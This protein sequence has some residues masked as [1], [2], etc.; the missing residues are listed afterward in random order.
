MFKP[1]FHSAGRV[2]RRIA[3]DAIAPNSHRSRQRVNAESVRRLAD[4]IRRHGQLVP[5]LVRATGEGYALISGQR[6]LKA[7]KLLGRTHV[8][9]I[10]LAA[11]E[12]DGA[13]LALAENMQRTPPHWLDE[14]EACQRLLDACPLS[15]EQLAEELSVSP[16]ALAARLKLLR[17]PPDVRDALRRLK[18]SEGHARALL[19]LPDA[20]A[21][22]ALAREAAEKRWS[23]RQLGTRI[24]QWLHPEPP[25]PSVS[26]V[27]RDNRII[28]NAITD[29]V[30]ELNHIGVEVA[31]RVEAHEDRIDV[32]VTIPTRKLPRGL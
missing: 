18:L 2:V 32:V 28:I 17:L 11:N 19:R 5:V 29:T 23:A 12:W 3:M 1:Q 16:S 8:E 21:Q 6:R 10:V 24:A 31:S 27:V 25:R 22:L 4:S 20:E 7:L 14:V 30:R 26:P 9:A 13:V 15:L